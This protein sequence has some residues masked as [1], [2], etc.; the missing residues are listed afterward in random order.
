MDGN[1][2]AT[3]ATKKIYTGRYVSIRTVTTYRNGR[4][5]INFW[6][7]L[8]KISESVKLESWI[9]SESLK[10]VAQKLILPRPFV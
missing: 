2:L 6:A 10:G 3:W 8:L 4:G 7:T 5:M 9:D 1:F